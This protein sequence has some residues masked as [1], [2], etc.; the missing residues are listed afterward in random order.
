[1]EPT[2]NLYCLVLMSIIYCIVHSH[3][4][5]SIIFVSSRKQLQVYREKALRTHGPRLPADRYTQRLADDHKAQLNAS[6]RVRSLIP[7][8][9]CPSTRDK[10]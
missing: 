4:S 6:Y 5:Y 3:C 2:L 10:R 9:S 1:M 8:S 7:G